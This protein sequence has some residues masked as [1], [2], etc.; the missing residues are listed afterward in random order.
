MDYPL[1]PCVTTVKAH[2][3]ELKDAQGQMEELREVLK[4]E[5]EDAV[6][7]VKKTGQLLSVLYL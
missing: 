1:T 7:E 2:K 4:V 3:V 6:D 5:I